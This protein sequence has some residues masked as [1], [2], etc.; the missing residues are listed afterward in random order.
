M[1]PSDF[2]SSSRTICLL[3]LDLCDAASNA[4]S[5]NGLQERRGAI[6][7][8]RMLSTKLDFAIAR[9]GMFVG[10]DNDHA[11]GD[12]TPSCTREDH[13]SSVIEPHGR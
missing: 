6:Q 10:T 3:A 7:R 9:L 1:T 2:D 5:V 12:A 11:A 13:P 4:R 8:M